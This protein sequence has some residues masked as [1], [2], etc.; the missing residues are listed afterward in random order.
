MRRE[1][2]YNMTEIEMILNYFPHSIWK[3]EMELMRLRD[4]FYYPILKK[5]GESLDNVDNRQFLGLFQGLTLSGDQ[6]FKLELLNKFLNS[7][8]KR[9]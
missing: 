7:Y 6:T 5:I 2:E 8:V 9:L 1:E 4:R 3:S